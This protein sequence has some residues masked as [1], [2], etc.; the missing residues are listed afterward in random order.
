MKKTTLLFIC[1]L[2]VLNINAEIYSGSCGDN[3]NYTLDTETGLLSIIGTGAMTNYSTRSSAPWYSNISYIKTV[4][5]A[6]GVTSIGKYA[7]YNC[8]GIKSIEIPNSVTSIG[9]YAFR[10]CF[11]L[12]SVT[13]PNSVTSIGS[14]T[15]VGCYF[16]KQNFINNSCLDDEANNYW[17]ANIVDSRENGIVVKDGILLKYTGD[18]SS[19]TIPNSVVSIGNSAFYGCSSLTSVTI[20]NSVTSIENYAFDGCSGLT[21][22]ILNSNSIVSKTYAYDYALKDVFGSQVREY[23]ICDDVTSIGS[24]AFYECS[25]LTSITISNSV[26]RIGTYAF[27]NCSGLKSV[28][29]PDKVT[30][31]GY[32]AFYGCSGL[33][34]ITIPNSVTSI[35]NNAF[36]GCSGL[37]SVTI[38][39]SVTSIL[40]YAF[41]GCS[42][43]K[44]VTI[45][46]SVTTIKDGAFSGCTSLS[47]VII[48]NSVTSMELR[49][50]SNCSDLT[51]VEI[52]SNTIVSKAYSSSS[53]LK[54]IFGSQVVEYILGNEVTSI[55]EYAFSDCSNIKKVVINSNGI[56]SKTYSSSSTI[57]D[58][59]GSQVEEYVIG[60]SVTSIGN[61]AFNGCTAVTSI[62]VGSS[63]TTI[64]ERAFANIDKLN[65][66]TCYSGAVPTADRTTFENSYINYVV[67]Y[68]PSA[69]VDA[70]K[71]KLPWSGFVSIVALPEPALRGDVNG[72]G[73]VNGTDI[74]AVINVIVDGEYDEK[75]D[76]NED[77]NVNGTDIQEVINII[78]NAE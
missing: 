67:L 58:I 68:V 15:F 22:V 34:S 64:G 54:D 21:K 32:D 69:S 39:H 38:P 74:Q 76:V 26:T 1:I 8:S 41:H 27:Y 66:F 18:E 24:Y 43:L 11:G 51:K 33:T 52:N 50:F 77:G 31:I 70:Y 49:A 7:F 37:T 29:I 78:V 55:G 5:I 19:I 36:Y 65:K 47:S 16:E 28:N 75:A 71:N 44:S 56:V 17:R 59:F 10:Y 57:K 42:S 6:D 25:N 53:S 35:S 20:S 2:S 30:Y 23:I 62:T 40:D 13:L 48:P 45:P 73:V 72:D 60:D 14:S 46:N 4:D 61:N 63:V 3:V 9:D 12:T